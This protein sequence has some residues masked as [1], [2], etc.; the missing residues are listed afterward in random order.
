MISITAQR[1][2]GAGGAQSR[3]IQARSYGDA[4]AIAG[5][6]GA[7]RM[8]HADGTVLRKV[9]DDWFVMKSRRAEAKP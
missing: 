1:P 7:V 6:W 9:R 2:D 4:E 8:E 3:T 5:E